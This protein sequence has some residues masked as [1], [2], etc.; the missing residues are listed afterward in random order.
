MSYEAGRL[1]ERVT[2]YT[3]TVSVNAIGAQT[4]E[5]TA[6]GTYWAT[7]SRQSGNATSQYGE[8]FMAQILKVYTRY[9][10]GIT[11]RCRVEWKG[12]MYFIKNLFIDEQHNEMMFNINKIE[13]E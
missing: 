13:N 4:T 3:P 6:V 7:V 2:I 9:H 8:V 12:E 5:W 10:E 1:T 11:D